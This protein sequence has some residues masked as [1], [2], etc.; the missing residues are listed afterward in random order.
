MRQPYARRIHGRARAAARFGGRLLG[1]GLM[2]VLAVGAGLAQ[3]PERYDYAESVM[4]TEFRILVYAAS[5]RAADSAATAAFTRARDLDASLSDWISDSELN[6]LSSLAGLDTCAHVSPEL[7]E[8]LS[9][10]QQVAQLTDGGFDVTVGP[11]TRLWRRA[12]RRG[13]LPSEASLQGARE[14]VG[15]RKLR[16][17][18]ARKCARLTA[19]DMRLDLGGIAK[20]YAADEMLKTLKSHSL[21]AALVDAGG[22][23]A[24]GDAPPGGSG[25][26]VETSTINKK[27]RLVTKSFSLSNTAVATSGDR[28]RY[29]EV[30]GVRYS[31]IVDPRTGRGITTR[32]LVTVLAPSGIEA[33]ALA[34]AIS[35]MGIEGLRLA[36]KA[37]YGARLIELTSTGARGREVSL[38][39]NTFPTSIEKRPAINEPEPFAGPSQTIRR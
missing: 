38:M 17:D 4:G 13:E 2:S 27:G 18:T 12:M 20:G 19:R 8:V 33:D 14:A 37:G 21:S 35:V 1:A 29:L 30:D 34:S 6:R 9:R 36:D 23:I 10:S 15:Y 11:L 3:E 28:Y 5:A 31:H 26:L 32:R 25:W 22:D 16:V 24:V 7:L 39:K